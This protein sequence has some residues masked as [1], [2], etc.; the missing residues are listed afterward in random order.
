MSELNYDTLVVR[1]EA[2][3]RDLPPGD[4]ED[5]R[6]VANTATLVYGDHDAVVVDTFTTIEQNQQ[7]IDWIRSHDRRV[8][9]VYLT[10]GHGDH[11]YGVGQLL[12]A[13]P[14]ARAVASAGAVA[15]ARIQAGDE[16]RDGFWGRL[17]PGQIPEPVIPDELA[18]DTITLE[19]HDLRVIDAARTDTTGTSALWIPSLRLIVAGDVVYSHTHMYLGETTAETRKEWTASL[20][21]LKQQAL[22]FGLVDEVR[23]HVVP[24]LLGGGTPLFSTL[25][26]AISLERTDVQV[27]PA[28]THLAFRVVR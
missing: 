17:F 20:N 13:F 16:W 10:H 25:D 8:T 4:N 27:T 6:W 11:V 28:A 14:G 7:L 21:R 9:H 3:T 19:G 1:R 26:S 2:L 22:P 15:V 18:G 5:L 24:V 23:V 12:E